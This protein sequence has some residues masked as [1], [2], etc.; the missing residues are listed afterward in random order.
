MVEE[1]LWP[2]DPWV[3]QRLIDFFMIERALYEIEQAATRADRLRFHLTMILRLLSR[4]PSS[5]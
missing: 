3:T 4:K 5:S 1:A 2:D